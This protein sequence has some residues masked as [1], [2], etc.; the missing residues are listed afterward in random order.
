[1]TEGALLGGQF[2]PGPWNCWSSTV[3]SH[4]LTWQEETKWGGRGWTIPGGARFCFVLVFRALHGAE[5]ELRL[6]TCRVCPPYRTLYYLLVPGVHFL[7]LR[8]K[9]IRKR[10]QKGND[11]FCSHNKLVLVLGLKPEF[12]P[13]PASLTC[14]LDHPLWLD[15]AFLFAAD[16]T[17]S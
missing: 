14:G 7:V 17:F 2:S 3:C 8:L 9:L 5:I 13:E 1:M 12:S 11:S 15:L 6:P 4:S 10:P 16:F